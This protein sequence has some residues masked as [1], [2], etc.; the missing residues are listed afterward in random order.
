VKKILLIGVGPLPFY[1]SEK[2]YGFGIRA[3]QFALP[4]LK[5]GHRVILVT[6]EFGIS[7]ESD[8]K[9]DLRYSPKAFGAIEHISL[10]EPGPR[11][12]NLLLTRLEE[13][14][15]THE[16][17]CIVAAGSTIAT[18]LAAS[19]DT[20]VPIW[21][22]MFGDL[23]AEV[24]AKTPF[25]ESN[26]QMDFFHQ[27]LS[28]VL[29]RGDRF[30]VVSE[31]QRGAAMGQLGLMGRLN[32]YT[33]GVEM[34]HTIPCA[35]NGDILPVR[36]KN[37]LRGKK[38]EK[39][40]FLLLCTGGFNTWMDVPT[41]FEGLE[42]A[43]EKNKKIHCVVT[44][45]GISGHHEDG[46]NK[47]RSLVSKS[48]YEGRFHLLGWLSNEDVDQVTLECDMGINVDLPIY[49][50][51]LGSRNRMLY[52]MQFGLPIVTT[53]TTEISYILHENAIAIG[54]PQGK[55]KVLAR[56]ILESS[57]DR[58]KVKQMA[59]QAREFAF[60]YFSFDETVAPLLHWVENPE[61]AMD[62]VE[63]VRVGTTLNRIDS[64]WHLWAFPEQ[65]PDIDPSIPRPPKAVIK[66]RPQGKTW[67]DRLIGK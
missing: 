5:A 62:N 21:M 9:V 61:P 32:Q 8:V 63:R 35:L 16:P 14:I 44:G 6:C 51:Y 67:W 37:I 33:L 15:K 31:M 13:I 53:L 22:D 25:M 26:E 41:L 49:E 54:V 17:D 55:P 50:S 46:F 48:P 7:R 59:L 2:M 52:W 40:D 64:Y 3:W 47:F 34:I 56:K 24:Q 20:P 36:K 38:V 12:F 42:A 45:G 19:I 39:N 1:K 43:M 18:N 28:R 30:S 11:N 4:L 60:Q 65:D 66:T 23:F 10:P 58:K 57:F 27:V 29:L